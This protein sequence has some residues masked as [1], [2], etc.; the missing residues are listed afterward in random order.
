V[1]L[2]RLLFVCFWLVWWLLC[3]VLGCFCWFWWVL[4]FCCVD[5]GVLVLVGCGVVCLVALGFWR[6]LLRWYGRGFG[7][8]GVFAWW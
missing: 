2:L 8:L 6:L 1:V 7:G 5:V 4:V 3:F